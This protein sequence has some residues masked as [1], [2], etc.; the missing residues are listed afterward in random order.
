MSEFNKFLT[1]PQIEAI[2]QQI[3]SKYDVERHLALSATCD[4]S[5]ARGRTKFTWDFL[6]CF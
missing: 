5:C 6:S 1:I 3:W 4:N 2:Y